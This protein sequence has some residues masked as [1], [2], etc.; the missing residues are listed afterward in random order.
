MPISKCRVCGH[1]FFAKPLLRYEN[2]PRAAQFL[3]D[4]ESLESDQGIDLDVCQCSGC[5]LVQLSNDAVHY[6]KEVVRAAAFSEEMKDYR[7][8][9]FGLF[10]Q[11]YFLNGKKIIEVGC[12]CG[13]Y[14]SIMQQCGVDAYGLEYSEESVSK[15]T[16]EGLRVFRG[17]VSSADRL[18]DAPYDAFY[19]LNYL[20]HLPDPNSTLTGIYEN[21]ADDAIGLVEVPNFDMILRNKLFSEFISD[22]LLYFTKETLAITL[23][24]NGFEIIE[25]HDIWHD[26]IISTIVKKK[27]KLDISHFY[28]YQV[29]LKNE[30][31][32]YIRPFKNKKVAIWGAGHQAFTVISSLN[33]AGNIR[34]VV[35]SATFKQGRFTPASH[36]PIVSPNALETDP[37]EAVIVMAAGYSDEVA[38]IIR[39]KFDSDTIKLSILRDFGLEVV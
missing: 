31:E 6:Y 33:L 35:D 9:Q 29:Q 26:Y 19:I 38:R 20:E 28:E 36:I 10:V 7:M 22:H 25:S 23:K 30:I 18:K 14:L 11:N 39:H 24:L 12:G 37:V 34:Y 13:E 32:E 3:P 8:K 1:D 27:K 4:T 17:F 15:C 21:L 5:G 16:E 2:M